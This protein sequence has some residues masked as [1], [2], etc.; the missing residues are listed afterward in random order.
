M[1]SV[2]KTRLFVFDP[3]FG[4]LSGHWENY[5]RRLYQE[6]KAR[7]Y[8][9]TVFGQTEYKNEIVKNINFEPVFQASAYNIPL[10]NMLDFARISDS[11]LDDFKRIDADR[12]R[13]GDIFIFHSIFPQTYN[14]LMD[15]T[16]ELAVSKKII[17]TL[18]FQFPPAERKSPV[19]G[20]NKLFHKL[21]SLFYGDEK[22]QQEMEWVDNTYVKFYQKKNALLQKI[23]G[24]SHI[25][26]A[27][28]DT[29]S[30]NFSGLFGTKVHYLP[31]PGENLTRGDELSAND[32]K[33]TKIKIGYFGHASLEKGGQFIR[34]LVDA[35]LDKHPDVQFVLHI[36]PNE[37]TRKYLQH[38]V[39][40][41]YPNVICYHGRL[42]Q[43][44]IIDLMNEVDII[45][46]PYSP[47]KYATMPSAV[48]TEG[49][50]MKKI[51]VLPE[52]TWAHR[53]AIKY[54]AG[55]A[56]FRSYN[57]RSIYKALHT[58]IANIDELKKKNQTAGELFANENNMKNYIDVF[59]TVLQNNGINLIEA[60]KAAL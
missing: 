27:S 36:H 47:A 7:G 39:T 16:L 41:S 34:Y 33:P 51:F 6:L 42:E 23:A 18:F 2:T 40:A 37:E 15:W 60:H 1:Q 8:E 58:A 52:G 46:M 53:E 29:L 13:D 20:L 54:D 56:A 30:Q 44:K 4:A 35:T 11:F 10:R 48:F 43:D 45:L 38:F 55:F 26:M 19:T 25:F 57:Q 32:A 22:K 9:V 59:E 50:P 31:M 24:K 12:F 3:Y 5:C 21:R 49:M 28:T 14:A 17:T